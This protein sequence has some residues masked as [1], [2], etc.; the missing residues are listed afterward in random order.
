M[1]RTKEQPLRATFLSY[2]RQTP[3]RLEL[4]GVFLW[5]VLQAGRDEMPDTL[6]VIDNYDSFTFNLVQM[7]LPFG[8]RIEV[9][10]NDCIR[11]EQIDGL[12]PDYILIS[13]GPK[14]PA[15][16]GISKEVIRRFQGRIPI[17]GI[18]LGLQCINEVYSGRTSRAPLPVHGKTSLIEHTGRGL[19]KGLTSPFRAARYHSLQ[20]LPAANSSLVVTARTSDGVAMG[21]AHPSL[22]LAGVQF[23]PESFLTEHGTV[24]IE[25]FL[26]DFKTG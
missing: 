22:P 11:V 7:F 8:L 21:L 20:A 17:L 26:T 6:L 12:A 13:P 3:S 15:G 23:H 1:H 25:N 5:L 24:I 14:D 4:G 18:C 10:R 9:T 2:A 19:F 16:A